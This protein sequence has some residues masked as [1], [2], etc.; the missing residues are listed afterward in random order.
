MELFGGKTSTEAGVCA[1]KMSY[2]S[3]LSDKHLYRFHTLHVETQQSRGP[4]S[5]HGVKWV[6]TGRWTKSEAYN[7]IP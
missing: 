4:V 7:F 5:L 3:F 6:L 1:R 2:N